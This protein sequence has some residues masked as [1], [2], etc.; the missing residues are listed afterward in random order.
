MADRPASLAEREIERALVSA[1]GHIDFPSTPDLTGRVRA[2]LEH[3]Q[4]RR[5]LLPH[6]TWLSRRR[7][8]VA[9]TLVIL[10]VLLVVVALTPPARNA[11]A[12]WLGLSSVEIVPL[13]DSSTSTAIPSGAPSTGALL[14]DGRSVSLAEARG[15]VAFP[16]LLPSAALVGQ[17]DAV[18]TGAEPPG[19][20]VTLTYAP[21]PDLPE[22]RETGVGLLITQFRGESIPF[23]QKGLPRGATA[24]PTS[25]NGARAFWIAGV[26]HLLIVRDGAGAM[27]EQPSRLAANTL[28]WERDGITY[29][30]ESSLDLDTAIRIAE[31]M[32]SRPRSHGRE[33]GSH[34]R[35]R[36]CGSHEA[37]DHT[38]RERMP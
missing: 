35:C 27:H 38:T 31:S 7:R 6:H 23:I 25:V 30:L 3:R 13:P 32:Q 21:R 8:A 2:D 33:P 4:N 9:A 24:T 26:P 18:Y 11:V 37:K 10:L 20:R 28:L 14:I 1:A 16:I 5:W 22:T 17:P 15:M 12:D 29:R 34:L 36:S 19:G